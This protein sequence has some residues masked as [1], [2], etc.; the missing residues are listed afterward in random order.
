MAPQGLGLGHSSGSHL[1]GPSA[2]TN[3]LQE[4]LGFSCSFYSIRTQHSA[5]HTV[6]DVK[7]VL[8]VALRLPG[9]DW[10]RA[11]LPTV[12]TWVPVSTQMV[13][14]LS[15]S[16]GSGYLRR[17]LFARMGL[18]SPNEGRRFLPRWHA[19]LAMGTAT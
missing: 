14:A 19:P 13:S 18:C 6:A 17:P 8:A 11:T 3:V 7:Q 9:A 1:E 10:G 12:P 2:R 4:G 15:P 16:W 5:Q